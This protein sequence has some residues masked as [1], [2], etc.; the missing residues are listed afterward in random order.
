MLSDDAGSVNPFIVGFVVVVVFGVISF[1]YTLIT[2]LDRLEHLIVQQ[3]VMI[4]RHDNQ[5]NDLKIEFNS[6]IK[7]LK[8]ELNKRI[9]EQNN[10]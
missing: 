1:A 6:D 7:E 9:D 8:L 3:N 2:R 10:H 5:L 4:Q